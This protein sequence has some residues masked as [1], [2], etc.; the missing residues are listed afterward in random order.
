[1][2]CH[3]EGRLRSD[4]RHTASTPPMSSQLIQFFPPAKSP[5][6]VPLLVTIFFGANDAAL[7][8][9]RSSRQHVPLATF[10]THLRAII[11]G[12]RESG[13]RHILLMTPPPIDERQRAL[14]N[15]EDGG[16]TLPERTDAVAQQYAYAVR[17]VCLQLHRCAGILWQTCYAMLQARGEHLSQCSA[18][19]RYLKLAVHCH[20]S[21][22]TKHKKHN[23]SRGLLHACSMLVAR[24][25]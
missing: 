11:G 21:E 14:A 3:H 9:R 10:K 20:H 25:A 15:P 2:H 13:V 16:S 5:A 18:V 23:A 6:N 24:H 1:M 8:G 7:P 22:A 4:G 19:S 12:V 17:E